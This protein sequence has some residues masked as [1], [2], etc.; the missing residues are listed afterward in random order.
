M[1]EAYTFDI[2]LKRMID[3][4]KLDSPGIDT[5][6]GSVI[7]NALAPAAVELAQMYIN[8]D[9]ILNEGFADTQTREYLIKRCKEHGII[10]VPAKGAI[11]KG[12]FNIDVPINSRFKL[13]DLVYYASEKISTGIFKMTCETPGIIGHEHLGTLVP[14]DYI[15]GLTSAEITEILVNGEDEE[16]TEVLRSRFFSKMLGEAFGGNKKDYKERVNQIQDVGGL[17]VY[18]ATEL[19]QGGKVK[20]VFI[21]SLWNKPT[22]SKI[23]FVD[24]EIDKFAP[25][26]HDVDVFAC[27]E[28]TINIVFSIVYQDGYTWASIQNQVLAMIDAYFLE[29]RKLWDS[30]N[31]IV[32][33][34]SQLEV[35]LMELPGIVDVPS[36]TL[37][38]GTSNIV[39]G[40]DAIPKRGSV[41]G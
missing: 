3:K 16:D 26:G 30:L 33:R 6:E 13:D 1:Y 25:I 24:A 17:K 40:A 8:L 12:V 14:I 32:V 21:D 37:N 28:T 11:M 39:L 10:P 22:A 35:R 5:R 2:I 7:Y 27:D 38:G 18:S 29:L 9:V 20:I 36:I 34:I 19:Q 23:S 15:D 4:V 41:S 31:N